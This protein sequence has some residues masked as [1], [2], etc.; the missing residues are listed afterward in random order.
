[1]NTPLTVMEAVT[2]RRSI[3]SFKPD[4][5]PVEILDQVVEAARLA[6][7]SWN[8][9]PTRIVV[10]RSPEQK[11]ALAEVAWRQKQILEAPVTLVF[12]AAVRS[13]EET[14]DRILEQARACGAWPERMIEFIRTSAPGFQAALG[15]KERE[16]AIKDAMIAATQAALAAE[17]L[18]LGTCFMNGWDEAGVKRVIGASDDPDLAIALVL[19]VGY[20]E[21]IPQNPGRL[22]KD[23]I[24]FTDRLPS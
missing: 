6:P 10:I 20:P 5:I 23:E 3:K 24:I 17:S 14:M 16:Y 13:W 19:P 11:E 15:D 7:S 8:F 9:Q 18:G 21:F 2:H 1:M 22:S 12:A 4:P